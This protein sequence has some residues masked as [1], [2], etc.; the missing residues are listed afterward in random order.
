MNIRLACALFFLSSWVDAAPVLNSFNADVSASVLQSDNGAKAEEQGALKVSEL[1]RIY[2]LGVNGEYTNDWVLLSA[3]YDLSEQQYSKNSQPDYTRLTGTLQ[4]DLGNNDQPLHLKVTHANQSLLNAPDAI[5]ISSNQD[6]RS[7]LTVEP[8]LRWRA[9]DADDLSASVR[10]TDVSYD[11]RSEKDSNIKAM[12][13]VWQRDINKINSFN[14]SLVSSK[15]A[16][17]SSPLFDY[18]LESAAMRYTTTLKRLTYSASAG[19]NKV[20]QSEKAITFTKPNYDFLINYKNVFNTLSFNLNR[21]VS[22]SSSGSGAMFDSVAATSNQI[23]IIDITS[24]TLN[25]ST[26]RLCEQC[27]LNLYAGKNKENYQSLL[28]DAVIKSAGVKLSYRVVRN[29]TIAVVFSE[30]KREFEL[31]SV[32]NGFEYKTYEATY[33]YLFMSKLGVNT[34]VRKLVRT[35]AFGTERYNEN[36]AGLTLTY[37][38]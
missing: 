18:T 4:M 37:S 36:I 27:L 15:T 31:G 35:S 32:S 8:S 24:A 21:A 26:D 29:G 20:T 25:W 34:F 38:F 33:N 19:V 12:Q 9:S 6:E 23:D 11:A 30:N 2:A 14:L 1:Q 13:L 17:D 28:E 10:T 7:I 22:D 16:F 3:G 5:D